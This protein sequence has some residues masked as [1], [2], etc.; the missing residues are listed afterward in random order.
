MATVPNSGP[1]L[2]MPLTKT[3]GMVITQRHAPVA[4]R[5][6]RMGSGAAWRT[7]A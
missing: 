6:I 2:R 1:R 3:I 5:S 7:S 4:R